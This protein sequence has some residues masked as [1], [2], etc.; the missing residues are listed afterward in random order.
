M[1]DSFKGTGRTDIQ[2]GTV[3]KPV[4]MRLKAASASTKND[5]SMPFGSTV[6]SSILTAHH[7]R[8]GVDYTSDLIASATES[9]N[10]IIAYLSYS[11]DMP[12][13]TYHL[14]ATVTMSL[15]GASTTFSQQ[16]DLNRIENKDR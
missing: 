9:G 4:Y 11:S 1:A 2:P 15:S 14:T 13:G 8:S 12:R 6:I 7:G 16:F 5:G 3:N 10:T